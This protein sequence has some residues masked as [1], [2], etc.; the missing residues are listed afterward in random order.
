[1]LKQTTLLAALLTL[2][3]FIVVGCGEETAVSPT[4]T[5]IEGPAFVLFYTDN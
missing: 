3:L 2:V 4:S 5:N 1:M